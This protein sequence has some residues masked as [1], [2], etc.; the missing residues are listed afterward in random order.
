MRQEDIRLAIE[1]AIAR[2]RF[3]D[4]IRSLRAVD[5]AVLFRG[6]F[7]LAVAAQCHRPAYPAA[8]LLLELEPPCDLSCEEA[9]RSVMPDWDISIEEVP[10]YLVTQFGKHELRRTVGVIAREA[11]L[12]EAERKRLETILYWIDF[13][14][15]ETMGWFI[16]TRDGFLRSLDEAAG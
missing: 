1:Q 7:P 8:Y 11:A 16:R 5:G 15:S 12:G 2:K 6:L 14:A 3:P 4:L 13:P 9:L 10:L